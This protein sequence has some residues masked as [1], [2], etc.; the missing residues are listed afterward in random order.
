MGDCV[1]LG[2]RTHPVLCQCPLSH[3]FRPAD[4]ISQPLSG[5]IAHPP[6][7][8]GHD[9]MSCSPF[10]ARW[11][12]NECLLSTYTGPCAWPWASAV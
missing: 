7:P 3:D 1:E 8:L 10:R 12:L 2:A 11:T 4:P 5:R 6:A 9:R